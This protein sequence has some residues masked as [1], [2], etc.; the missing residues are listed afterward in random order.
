MN[1]KTIFLKMRYLLLLGIAIVAGCA[2]NAQE[3]P[4]VAGGP[5]VPDITAP[6]VSFTSPADTNTNVPLDRKIYVSFSEAMKA[7]TIAAAG[8]LIVVDN[9]G[10]PV[11]GTVQTFPTSATFTPDLP[12]VNNTDYTVTVKG[13][14]GGVADVAD[15]TMA[16][17]Y[18]FTFQTGA[19]GDTILPTVS[20]TSPI[21][22]AVDVPLNKVVY[23]I[24]SE[25]MDPSTLAPITPLP[26][27]ITMTDAGGN[28]VTG[29]VAAFPTSATFTP[30]APLAINTV[31]TVTVKG[32]LGGVADLA[33]NE[34]LADHVFSFTTIVT[35]GSPTGLPGPAGAV[36]LGTAGTYGVMA[37]SGM[38]LTTPAKSHIYGDVGILANA[39]FT[40]FTL[41]IASPSASS[42]LS[43]YVSGEITSGPDG[44]GYNSLNYLNM[45]AAFNDLN[46]T[47][48]NN[49]PTNNPAPLTPPAVAP[50][51]AVGGTFT[52]AG[53]D[54]TGLHLGPGIYAS[55][56]PAGTLSLSNTSGPLVLDAEGNADAV[57]IFQASDITTTSGSVILRN[58]AQSKNVYWILTNTAT[59]GDGTTATV[60]TGTILAGTHVTV[61]LD[62]SVEGRVLAGAGLV[63]GALTIN[64]GV[65]TVP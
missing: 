38:T 4:V 45:V 57:F 14:V 24:F 55:N 51:I 58:G 32:P 23:V 39:S 49:N 36:D 12:L 64:G 61:G 26:Q 37:N 13:G 48:T 44:S 15:N 11:N 35:S 8:A 6:T 22:A 42:P 56:T 43:A 18:I 2:S 54:L 41:S 65:V 46:T 29:S 50:A 1:K 62:T 30:S 3:I 53:Q 5:V 17:D 63:T 20:L 47:W 9:L 34:M 33:S 10:A 21:D 59:I 25:V 19:A 40:G 7:S 31:Y 27:T 60:F 28:P 16:G 52:A